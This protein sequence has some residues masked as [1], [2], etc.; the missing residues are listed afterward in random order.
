MFKII[1]V[2]SPDGTKRVELLPNKDTF[3]TLFEKTLIEFNIDSSRKSQWNLFYDRSSSRGILYSK[4]TLVSTTLKHGDI[5]Y[6]MPLKSM[7]TDATMSEENTHVAS[8]EV[9]EVDLELAKQNGQII[10]PKDEQ[11]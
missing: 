9:D 1:R 6:L 11:M 5:I 3:Y 2:Q 8:L 10:R 4:S 7:D